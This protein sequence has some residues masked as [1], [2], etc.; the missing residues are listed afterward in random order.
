MKNYKPCDYYQLCAACFG[1]ILPIFGRGNLVVA[2]SLILQKFWND[3]YVFV[4][5]KD[6]L[7]ALRVSTSLVFLWVL[8]ADGLEYAERG[9]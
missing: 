1:H 7:R 6:V 5:P 2:S 9:A 8:Y 3:S 4:H